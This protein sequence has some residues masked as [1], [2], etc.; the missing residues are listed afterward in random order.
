MK[1]LFAFGVLIF[2]FLPTFAQNE[3]APILE[4]D[5]AYKDWTLKGVTDGQDATLRDLVKGKKLVAVVYFAPWCPNWRHDAPMLE[6]LYEKYKGNGFEIVAVGEYGA[7]DEMN[8]NIKEFN[9][10]FP[11]VFE[12]FSRDA[13]QTTLHYTYRTG[14]GDTRKW[15]SPYYVF[16]EPASL[17]K[18]SDVLINRTSIINGEMIAIDGEKFIR[19]KL[20]LPADESKLSSANKAQTEVCDPDKPAQ[21]KKPGEKP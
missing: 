18:K 4:K 6:K 12:S 11:M 10:T 9:I 7:T 1:L 16:L 21:L 19:Q 17:E 20:G 14:T 13:R 2:G 3:Q 15:G 8:A 5:I